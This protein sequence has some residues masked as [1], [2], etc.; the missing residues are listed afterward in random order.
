[1]ASAALAPGLKE[2]HFEDSQVTFNISGIASDAAAQATVG[3]AVTLDTATAGTVK[4]CGDGDEIYG[5]VESAEYR[6]QSGL[7]LVTVALRFIGNLVMKT[8]ET[9]AIGA[10]MI[11]GGAG[12]VKTRSALTVTDTGVT[13]V[14]VSWTL[15]KTKPCTVLGYDATPTP[16]TVNVAFGV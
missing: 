2:Y 15:G 12:T 11:G 13:G 14:A 16:Q 5:R 4:L 8:G 1:M 6:A 7:V 10:Q 3:Y 9:P